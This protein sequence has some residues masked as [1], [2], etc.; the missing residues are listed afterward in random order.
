MSG[1][2]RDSCR[3][4]DRLTCG[5]GNAWYYNNVRVFDMPNPALVTPDVYHHGRPL[6]TTRTYD[7]TILKQTWL[8][9]GGNH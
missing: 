9:G 1:S 4:Q 2:L 8:F 6:A 5:G 3:L 7:G